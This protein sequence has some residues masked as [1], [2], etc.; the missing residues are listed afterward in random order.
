MTSLSY[1]IDVNIT[2]AIYVFAFWSIVICMYI[3]FFLCG[4]NGIDERLTKGIQE[5]N[6]WAILF[7]IIIVLM[8]FASVYL[9]FV[10]YLLTWIFIFWMVI[11]LFVPEI[12]LIPIP[13]IPFII[14]IPL[15]RPILEYVPPFKALTDRG[16]LP[17]MRRVIFR[18][19]S[20]QS[21]KNLFVL[22]F[23]DIYG[24][25]FEEIKKAIE[26]VLLNKQP[27]NL[28]NPGDQ[29]FSKDIQDDEMKVRTIDDYEKENNGGEEVKYENKENQEVLD[30]INEEL[31]LCLIS[32]K[33]FQ[34]P[35]KNNY[36]QGV[37][38]MKNYFECYSKSIKSYIDSKI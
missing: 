19:F 34:T 4:I 18:I 30:L 29:D 11:I 9:N 27:S 33:S 6:I 10:L 1:F 7:F 20:E 26:R 23:T 16:I 8:F 17:L 14:P 24:F 36:F 35:D 37:D 21:L 31:E 13:F 3:I 25:L 15:K 38:D 12:I 2:I 32:K 5:M 28:K 22:T